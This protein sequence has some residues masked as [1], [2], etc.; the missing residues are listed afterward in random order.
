VTSKS[1]QRMAALEASTDQANA[2]YNTLENA[3]NDYKA[4]HQDDVKEAEAKWNAV[5]VKM[6]KDLTASSKKN[7]E[8]DAD[9]KALKA[10]AQNQQRAD[11]Q[12]KQDAKRA[13]EEC[14][15]M[16]LK[17]EEAIAHKKAIEQKVRRTESCTA[18]L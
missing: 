6:Q 16:K 12:A 3:F 11:V 2:R 10:Q 13:R 18:M 1:N 9:F 17:M 4:S 15:L 5:K 7:N 14:E 8:L